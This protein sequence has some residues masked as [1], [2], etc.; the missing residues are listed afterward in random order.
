M[1][2][3]NQDTKKMIEQYSARRASDQRIL[4]MSQCRVQLLPMKCFLALMVILTT[5]MCHLQKA[6]PSRNAWKF[7]SSRCINYYI[8]QNYNNQRKM[9]MFWSEMRYLTNR[10]HKWL[11]RNGKPFL[12]HR[13]LCSIHQWCPVS[14][15]LRFQ[16][17][18]NLH[19]CKGLVILL[20]DTCWS[21]NKRASLIK[22]KCHIPQKQI[23]LLKRHRVCKLDFLFIDWRKHRTLLHA[24]IDYG[25]GIVIIQLW[26]P[27]MV[28]N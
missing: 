17:V 23:S 2:H 9:D 14:L 5:K 20:L 6:P 22:V 12:F 7:S 15:F 28:P 11:A 18:H 26:I 3:S 4:P 10:V 24:T 13:I 19:G 27:W 25:Q 16:T 21:T 8:F 1:L